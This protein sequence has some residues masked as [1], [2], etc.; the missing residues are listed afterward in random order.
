MFSCLRPNAPVDWLWECFN[1][2][3]ELR[4]QL[5]G[6]LK[7]FVGCSNQQPRRTQFRARWLSWPSYPFAGEKLCWVI[8][9]QNDTLKQHDRLSSNSLKPADWLECHR[10]LSWS[11]AQSLYLASILFT[12]L[13]ISL[14]LSQTRRLANSLTNRLNAAG[15]VS[16]CRAKSPK[17]TQTETKRIKR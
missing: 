14:Y 16:D 5:A 10:S 13:A 3:F 8:I 4:I 6:P 17:A 9:H 11:R 15:L 2:D 1:F 12:F 7:L